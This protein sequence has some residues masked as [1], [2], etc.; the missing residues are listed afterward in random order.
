MLEPT[1]FKDDLGFIEG[2]AWTP[3]GNLSLVSIDRGL[4]YTLDGSTGEVRG[5]VETAGGP[6]GLVI[7]EHAAFVAQNGGV[8]GASGQAPAGVQAVS[9]GHATYVATD[10]FEAPNDICFGPDGRLLVTDPTTDAA[11]LEQIPGAVLACDAVSGETEVLLDGLL[12]PNGLAVDASG[13]VLYLGQSFA[14]TIERIRFDGPRLVREHDIFCEVENGR[15]DGMALDRDGNLW[16]AV[17]ASGGV[18]VYDPNGKQLE[19]VDCGEGSLTTNVCFGGPDLKR[20]FITAAKLGAVLT[21][22]APVAGLPLRPGG[23]AATK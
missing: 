23:A 1:V 14:R 12:C 9:D 5:S 8:F 21:L 11:L 4:V 10:G 18:N 15:P 19:R 20:V 13:D 3:E 17:P 2:P 6:N 16:V 22:T 7:G